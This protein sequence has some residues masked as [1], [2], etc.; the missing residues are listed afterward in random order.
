[1]TFPFDLTHIRRIEYDNNALGGKKLEDDLRKTLEGI[2][3]PT[4]KA[5]P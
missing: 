3:T 5:V 2:L 1:V 4:L